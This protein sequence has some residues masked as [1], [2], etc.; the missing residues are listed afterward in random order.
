MSL[1]LD[2]KLEMS[3]FSEERML[4]AKTGQKLILFFLFFFGFSR[5]A[6]MSY[7]GSQATGLIR[8]VAAGLCQNHS[9]MGSEP[10]LRPI[11]QLMATPDP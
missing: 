4:K 9:N 7:G 8:A 2:Q 6:P 11:P 3:K 5:A 10:C 1:T